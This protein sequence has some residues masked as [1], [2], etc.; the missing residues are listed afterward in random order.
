ME[1]CD[2]TIHELKLLLDK[3]EASSFDIVRSVEKRIE[4]VEETICSYVDLYMDDAY[5]KAKYVDEMISSGA[6]KGPLAGIPVSIKSNMC[7]KGKETTCSSRILEGFKP[8][9]TATAVKKLIDTDAVIIGMTNMDEFAM[10]SS[11]ENSAVKKTRNPW[12]TERVPGGSSGGSASAVSAGEAVAALG[13]DTGGSIRQPASFCGV[14]GIKPTYGLVSRYGLVA[15]ASSLDQIG[16][17]ARDAE[18]CAIMLNVISGQDMM[19]STSM[20][21]R[22]ADYTSGLNSSIKGMRIG[23]PVEY[24]GEGLDG[25]VRECVSKAVSVFKDLGAEVFEFSL[26][27]TDYALPAYYIISSAEA[28]SNLA[29]YDGIRYGRAS[30][31]C[32]DIYSLYYKTRSEGFGTEAKRRIMLGT[33]ALSSGYYDAYYKKA[34]QVRTL[35]LK[36]FEEAFERFDLIISPTSPTIPFKLGEKCENP[37]EMYLSDVCTVPVN[38]AGLP[39]VS[40]PCGFASGLPVGLQIIGRHFSEAKILNAAHVFQNATEFH[41]TK[42]SAIKE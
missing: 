2:L 17:I 27:Y 20:D 21:N 12:D 34:Q 24:Y 25:N 37:L 35:I 7:L 10:G 33:Y 40:I 18:D 30:I 23:V 36:D 13:S 32:E 15:F 19:D 22:E 28:S 11:T 4:K 1:L 16:T 6:N 42:P 14:T 8:P 29:R 38:I 31:E 3:K 26:K 5:K 41:R 39:A 9:Y